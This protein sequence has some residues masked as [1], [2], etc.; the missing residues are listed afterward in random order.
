MFLLI[1]ALAHLTV[2]LHNQVSQQAFSSEVQQ[3]LTLTAQPGRAVDEQLVPLVADVLA[4]SRFHI[5]FQ[6]VYSL[7]DGTL[8]AVEAL[9]RF[10]VEPRRTPDRWFAAATAAG[11]GPD[12]EIAAIAAA[13]TGASDLP[14]HVALS[15][16]ASPDTLGDARLLDL[17]RTCTRQL[18]VEITEH[19]VV[20]DYYVLAHTVRAMRALGV[21]IAVDDAGAGISSLR[22]I[23]QLAPEVIKLDISLTQGV[24][25]SALRRALAGAL[26]DFAQQSDAQLIVEGIE[27]VGDLTT[28]TAMGADAVQGYLVGRPGPLPVALHSALIASVGSAWV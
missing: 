8:L 23:V 3:A 5:V 27:E 19:D 20:D 4:N 9:S 12:L 6:P 24:G 17:V 25:T 26:I 22:H 18:V 21:R 1:G 13:I 7:S 10:D 28:W 15:V 14:D 11:L 16:N 2:A